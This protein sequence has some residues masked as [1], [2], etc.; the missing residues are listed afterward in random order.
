VA[1]SVVSFLLDGLGCSQSFSCHRTFAAC[2][3]RSQTSPIQ[4]ELVCVASLT[5][6]FFAGWTRVGSNQIARFHVPVQDQRCSFYDVIPSYDLLLTLIVSFGINS[7]TPVGGVGFFSLSLRY[8]LLRF[9]RI[10]E[11]DTGLAV[12][13]TKVSPSKCKLWLWLVRRQ[14]LLDAPSR[15]RHSESPVLRDGVH[16]FLGL[17]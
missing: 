6:L 2:Y 13:R 15:E 14:R 1:D 5:G 9:R 16:M 8:R 4:C 7:I 12:H 11:Q 10:P 17:E 3:A